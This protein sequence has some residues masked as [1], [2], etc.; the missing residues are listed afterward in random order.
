MGIVF[1]KSK[2][3]EIHC[4][5]CYQECLY[6]FKILYQNFDL[7]DQQ[8]SSEETFWDLRLG[9]ATSFQDIWDILFGRLSHDVRR[10]VILRLAWE[11]PPVEPLVAFSPQPNLLVTLP[12]HQKYG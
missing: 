8:K 10:T 3:L 2:P 12:R 7:F 6:F 11:R 1:F 4:K 9:L 5:I